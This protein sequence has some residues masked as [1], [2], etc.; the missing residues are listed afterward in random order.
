M[1]FDIDSVP[2]YG[3]ADV[4]AQDVGP[5]A[6]RVRAGKA[7]TPATKTDAELGIDD[8]AQPATGRD[9]R[10]T[11]QGRN[12]QITTPEQRAALDARARGEDPIAND[13]LAGMIVQGIPAAGLGSVVG[14]AVGKVAPALAPLAQGA[15]T[16]AASNPDAPITGAALG[17]VATVPGT[18]RALA[19][20][21]KGAGARA[22]TDVLTQWG[23]A[24][25]GAGK[26]ATQDK[27]MALA[28]NAPE[29]ANEVLQRNGVG[30]TGQSAAEAQAALQAG[31]AKAGQAQGQAF[32][33]IDALA[34]PLK[35]ITVKDAGAAVQDLIAK[36]RTGP[37]A[38]VPMAD[39]IHTWLKDFTDAN[40]GAAAKMTAKD[41]NA[42]ISGLEA[43]GY[44]GMG[45]KLPTGS[46]KVA[47]RQIAKALNGVLNEHVDSVAK[48][49]DAAS[50][51]A[52]ALKDSTFDYRVLKT[53]QPV[54]AAR[55]RAEFYKISGIQ[56]AA[57][58]PMTM[59]QLGAK[60][61][62]G[63]ARAAG[64]VPRAIDR[65]LARLFAG[66]VTP[67]AIAEAK[68]AGVPDA[69]LVK[70]VPLTH[71]GPQ[72][73]TSVPPGAMGTPFLDEITGEPVTQV[74]Q[75]GFLPTDAV[76]AVGGR[77]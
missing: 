46:A 17:A 52:Q 42:A 1:A 33:T 55:E 53:M 36:M 69:T 25:T 58:T 77:K 16:G 40:G 45:A 4:P 32:D 74:G 14:G 2:G 61:A 20:W 60:A 64:A 28:K 21:A 76:T 44:G 66:P 30:L 11:M 12:D 35:P 49:S 65:A 3:P 31:L 15:T 56:K 38:D 72:L 59:A 41:L 7:P 24:A 37:R 9:V 6:R 73:P 62:A 22:G 48:T 63:A 43:K 51:A 75:G 27:I 71:Q 70:L 8:G 23:Q 18:A 50:Q 68:A 34:S 29:R 54:A 19:T 10:R 39:A 47:A 57:S 5:E 13:P 67:Q 26:A